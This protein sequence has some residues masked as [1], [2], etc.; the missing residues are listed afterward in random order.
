M[1]EF[2]PGC[3]RQRAT[4]AYGQWHMGSRTGAWNETYPTQLGMENQYRWP[5]QARF[6]F[7][8]FWQKKGRYFHEIYVTVAKPMSFKPL[9]ALATRSVWTLWHV[10]IVGVF[11]NA[12]LKEE[13]FIHLLEGCEATR[14]CGRL[15]KTLYGLKQNCSTCYPVS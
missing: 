8:G 9:M 6:V 5:L 3:M 10:D 1:T 13:V 15:K 12:K 14:K 11:L 7:K 2:L 4:K